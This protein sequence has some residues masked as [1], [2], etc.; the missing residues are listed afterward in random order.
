VANAITESQVGDAPELVESPTEGKAPRGSLIAAA[1][2]AVGA[3][4]CCIVPLA[5]MAAG[6]GGAWMSYFTA[7]E[8]YRPYFLGA[9]VA[10]LGVA[11]YKLYFVPRRCE[12]NG[13][14][15]DQTSLRRSRRILWGITIALIPVL[16]FPY[17]FG[18]FL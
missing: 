14:C 16:T 11:F 3:S 2:A 7:M 15:V 18:Y 8:P 9:T 12:A 1:L 4:A 10:C 5:L 13:V 17:Y 6:I